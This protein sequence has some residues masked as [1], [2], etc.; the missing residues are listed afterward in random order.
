MPLIL[1]LHV[2]SKYAMSCSS[3]PQSPHAVQE[4]RNSHYSPLLESPTILL[5]DVFLHYTKNGKV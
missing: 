4:L 2:C 1:A 3:E 5:D